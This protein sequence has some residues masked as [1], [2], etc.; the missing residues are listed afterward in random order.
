LDDPA[1]WRFWSLRKIREQ[2]RKQVGLLRSAIIAMKPGGT[3]V[4]CTCSF[5]PEENECVVSAQRKWFADTIQVE[6]IDLPVGSWSPGLTEWNGKRLDDDLRHARRILP[7]S[8]MDGFFLI[9]LTKLI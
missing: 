2:A 9:K 4:Y 8:T 5:A 1:T 6:P 7:T 3:L